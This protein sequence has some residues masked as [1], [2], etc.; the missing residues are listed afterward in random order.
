MTDVN[1][2]Q[3][4]AQVGVIVVLMPFHCAEC[5]I[6]DDS[7]SVSVRV[8]TNEQFLLSTW[9]AKKPGQICICRII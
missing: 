4:T 9:W 2:V 1:K 7:V 5:S 8:E 6:C 3:W